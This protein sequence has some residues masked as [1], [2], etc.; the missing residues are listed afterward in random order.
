MNFSTL[1]FGFF[2]FKIYGVFVAL[3][4]ALGVWLFYKYIQKK[5]LSVDV[6]LHSFWYW[7]LFGILVGRL[8]ILALSPDI[9]QQY[10]LF[11]LFAFWDGGVHLYGTIFGM[12]G[13]IYW[14]T[15]NLKDT[16]WHWLDGAAPLLLYAFIIVD[17]GAFL[18]GAIY[19]TSAEWGGKFLPWGVRYETFGVDILTPVHPVTLYAL[20]FHLWI[21]WFFQKRR[22]NQKFQPGQ[23]GLYILM[24]VILVDFVLSFVRSFSLGV[25]GGVNFHQV[26]LVGS[27]IG[28]LF[29]YVRRYVHF[30]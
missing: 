17:I 24:S 18:T 13:I 22:K 20:F 7:F 5:K 14:Q 3:A 29:V 26:I 21:V 11:G 10:G 15:R 1:F 30:S 25:Y 19:G 2:K 28:L 8:F 9:W 27:F 4:F 6:F 12:L 23:K 16:F